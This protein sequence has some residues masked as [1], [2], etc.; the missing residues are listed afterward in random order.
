MTD[1]LRKRRCHR[2]SPSQII[3]TGLSHLYL[4]F[5]SIDPKTFDIVPAHPD[6]VDLY[7]QFTARKSSSMQT[8]IAIG[9]F[10][11]GAAGSAT[12]ET[13]K[14]M[15][16]RVDARKG[17]ITS[18]GDFMKKSGFQGVDLDWEYPSAVDRGGSIN[19]AAN[20]V[21]LVREMR[22]A[23]GK[24]YGISVT[25][26]PD[27]YLSGFD[28]KG[29]EPY[30][31]FFNYLSYDLRAPPNADTTVSAHTDVRK[32]EKAAAALWT[33]RVDS[34]KVNLGLS[35]AGRGYTLSD[36]KCSHSDCK[37]TG[38]S[39]PGPCTGEAGLL[40]NVEINDLIRD[41]HLKAQLVPN[42]MSKEV[43]WDNQWIGY[44]DD[45][46][47]GMKTDWAADN[48]FG[49]TTLWSLDMDSGEGR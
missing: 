11:F 42:S 35:K 33:A 44:D 37:V 25:L 27:S 12:R 29:M 8:W 16:S 24:N 4:A 19:D 21:A 18:L 45:E 23:W 1:N 6:D 26:P 30:V 39:K 34:K 32:I 49:G 15:T 14:L 22:A 48:C 3:T 9:G 31:D 36:P 7:G 46:T 40:A 10:Q 17:F 20:Y 5:A 38:P 28:P 43:S 13:W 2:I 41:K 47:L